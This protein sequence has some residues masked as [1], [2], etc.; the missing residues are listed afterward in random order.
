MIYEISW[1]PLDVG[2]FDQN[3]SL[4]YAI[5]WLL[6]ICN[7]SFLLPKVSYRRF[8]TLHNIML[9]RCASLL[10][11]VLGALIIES[12]IT[13]RSPNNNNVHI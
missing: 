5:F 2:M 4:K 3:S 12:A 7:F 9:G 8:E 10:L 1:L 6:T 13:Y 11:L